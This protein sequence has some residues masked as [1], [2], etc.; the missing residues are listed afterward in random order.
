MV[1]ELPMANWLEWPH[2]EDKEEGPTSF[3]VLFAQ[4]GN[5]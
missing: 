3:T 1:G 4:N 5:Q 2:A